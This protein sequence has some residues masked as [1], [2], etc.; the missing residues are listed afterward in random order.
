MTTIS[1]NNGG[2]NHSAERI[3]EIR[4]SIAERKRARHHSHSDGYN[5][6]LAAIILPYMQEDP[7]KVY[8]ITDLEVCLEL[9]GQKYSGVG[10]ATTYMVRVG[11]I[12]RI[13][14]A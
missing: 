2:V 7:D 4:R 11:L 10:P 1:D 8:P 14:K 9:A 13:G 3:E 5:K 12:E 6:K